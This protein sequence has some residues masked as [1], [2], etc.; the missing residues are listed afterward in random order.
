MP[1]PHNPPESDGHLII[2]IGKSIGR[3]TSKILAFRSF[4]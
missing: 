4:P 1:V 2:R 3:A